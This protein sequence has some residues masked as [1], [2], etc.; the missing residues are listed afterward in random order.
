MDSMNDELPGRLA[1]A[2]R[3][4][5]SRAAERSARVSPDRVAAR[6]VERLRREGTRERPRI[7][8]MR[9]AVLR[10]AAAIVLV[11]AAGWAVSVTRVSPPQTATRL[12]VVIPAMDSLTT[13]QLESVL[14]AAGQVRA[15][16][17]GPVVP[18][19]GSL[20]SLSE[21]QLQQVLASL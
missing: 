4:L 6:V 18:S 3:E 5:D 8:F 19:N 9:P 12:P 1:A 15:A 2:L 10:V 17:F 7:W 21:K 16:N 13:G 14:E 11:V 20:D